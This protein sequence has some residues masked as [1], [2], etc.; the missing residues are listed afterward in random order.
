VGSRHRLA[1][2]RKEESVYLIRLEKQQVGWVV[3]STDSPIVFPLVQWWSFREI[4][5]IW[6]FHC[7]TEVFPRLRVLGSRVS[8]IRICEASKPSLILNP[9]HLDLS[10]PFELWLDGVQ[11]WRSFCLSQEFAVLP[12][13][14]S[15]FLH[16]F[17]FTS[18]PRNAPALFHNSSQN[19]KYGN[20][21]AMCS[22]FCCGYYCFQYWFIEV[23]CLCVRFKSLVLPFTN[24]GSTRA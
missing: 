4:Q 10:E 8:W 7:P 15:S 5:A 21:S 19:S 12:L 11:F 24:R 20:I 18:L 9:M 23:N 22:C 14:L 3:Q 16:L 1:D 17:E 13:N 6:C 2:S